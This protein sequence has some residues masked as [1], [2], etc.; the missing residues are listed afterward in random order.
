MNSKF[1]KEVSDVFWRRIGEPNGNLAW[2]LYNNNQLM[3]KK[4]N[5]EKNSKVWVMKSYGNVKDQ[6]FFES[7]IKYKEKLQDWNW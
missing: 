5:S 1:K 6:V 2:E 3:G 7:S 4:Y